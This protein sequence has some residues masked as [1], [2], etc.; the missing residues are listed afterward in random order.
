MKAAAETARSAIGWQLPLPYVQRQTDKGIPTYGENVG[1]VR[2]D[3]F[4]NDSKEELVP[5]EG[6]FYFSKNEGAFRPLS[7]DR[8]LLGSHLPDG[9][10]LEF[11]P[12]AEGRVQDTNGVPPR[13]FAWLL[14]RET[15]T[16]GN[17]IVYSWRDFPGD[18][19]H[20]PEISYRI[21]YGPGAPPWNN[22]HFVQFLYEDRPDWFED[23]RAGFLGPHGQAAQDRS[24]RHPGPDLTGHL[25]GDF[26]QDGQPD[27]LVRI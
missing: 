15:D 18:N 26:N 3:M 8:R 2:Q 6:G 11:G 25:A 7:A 16:H 10:R 5:V 13:V 21:R 14:E 4:I 24:D 9:T 23:C 27:Y 17:T 19:E 1:F 22:F 12:S 20:Q